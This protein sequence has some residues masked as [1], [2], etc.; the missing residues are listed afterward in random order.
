MSHTTL[1]TGAAGFAGS[2]LLDLLGTQTSNVVAWHRPLTPPGPPGRLRWQPVDMLDRRAVR[3]AV[4][5]AGPSRVYHCAGAA[6]VGHAWNA[7]TTT[8]AVNARGT[9]YLLEAL[10]DLAP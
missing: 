6:H 1:V 8:L 2:H 9:H 5:A 3:E 10:R 7:R 4:A